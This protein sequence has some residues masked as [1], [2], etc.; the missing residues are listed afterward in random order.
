MDR[1][2]DMTNILVEN[3]PLVSVSP[4]ISECPVKTHVYT[5]TYTVY[6]VERYRE[7]PLRWRPGS[8]RRYRGHSALITYKTTMYR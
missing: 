6:N 4:F 2:G 7:A 8:A 3:Y 1:S 5:Y